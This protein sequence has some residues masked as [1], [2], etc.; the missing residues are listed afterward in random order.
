LPR[1]E[2]PSCEQLTQL[3][4][5]FTHGKRQ[6]LPAC[7]IE[8]RM[9]QGMGIL[10]D[11]Q[12]D[13]PLAHF[14]AKHLPQSIEN[15]Q[16]WCLDPVFIQIDQEEA[17]LL[18]NTQLQLDAYEARHLIEDLNTYLA[19]EELRIHYLNPHQWV[20]EGQLQ[21]QTSTLQD[22][23]HRNINTHQP[24]GRD[25]KRWR[26]LL[27]EIQMFLHSHS[28]NQAREQRGEIAPNSVWLWGGSPAQPQHVY[29][30][31]IDVVYCDEEFVH[32]IALVCDIKHKPLPIHIDEQLLQQEASLLIYTDQLV[33]IRRHDVFGWFE[34]LQR[35]DRDVLAPLIEFLRQGKLTS[36]TLYSDTLSMTLTKKA[37]RRW[38]QRRKPFMTSMLS[39]RAD[40]AA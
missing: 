35:L 27:N 17:V 1:E 36:L 6:Q 20:L 24:Q 39:L 8:A 31:I 21:L 23:L 11:P 5:F 38:W 16:L 4:Q 26:K 33:A 34:Y 40:Y 15:R 29:E 25:E 9:L 2:W 12:L 37:L 3:C 30:P 19:E 13:V 7:S 32:D 28:V 18:A 14:R 10:F 22:V